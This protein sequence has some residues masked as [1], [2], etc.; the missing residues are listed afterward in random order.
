M[1]LAACDYLHRHGR[2]I[3]LASYDHRMNDA[4]DAMGIPLFDL[5]DA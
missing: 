1:H 3:E 4:A 5:S 2:S